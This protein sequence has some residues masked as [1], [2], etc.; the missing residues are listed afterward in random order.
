MAWEWS[1]TADAH[2]KALKNLGKKSMKFLSECFAEWK[3]HHI[4]EV[5]KTFEH[6]L[7]NISEDVFFNIPEEINTDPFSDGRYEHF[8]SVAKKMNKGALVDFIW[9]KASEQRTC[10]NGGYDPW[11]CPHGCHKV[12][13]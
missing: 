7:F 10:E 11:M 2:E 5:V 8:L 13:W 12:E 4:S 1:H 9:E 6:Q 3:C